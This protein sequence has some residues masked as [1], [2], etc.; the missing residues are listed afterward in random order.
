LGG[1]EEEAEGSSQDKAGENLGAPVGCALL[2]II[3]AVLLA[4]EVVL[5]L[6]GTFG[7]DGGEGCVTIGSLAC[8]V[9]LSDSSLSGVDALVRSFLQPEEGLSVILRNALAALVEGKADGGLGCR[10]SGSGSD[11]IAS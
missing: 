3:L 5:L 9:H 10:V 2:R 4:L 6:V 1:L 7:V 8:G 11:D